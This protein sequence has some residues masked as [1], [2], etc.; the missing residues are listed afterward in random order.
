MYQLCG[1]ACIG[2][3]IGDWSRLV[4]T[5]PLK[6][7]LE[8][9]LPRADVSVLLCYFLSEVTR[10]LCYHAAIPAL[11]V[12]LFVHVWLLPMGADGRHLEAR[13][14]DA[15]AFCNTL[16]ELKTLDHVVN[17]TLA[18]VITKLS[19]L[20][21]ALRARARD[22]PCEE[23][24]WWPSTSH[25]LPDTSRITGWMTRVMLKTKRFRIFHYTYA[26]ITVWHGLTRVMLKP[27]HSEYFIISMSI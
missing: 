17:H 18:F 8:N 25:E 23:R 1:V 4:D 24:V 11:N 10:F 27:K 3:V 13:I 22:F 20:M 21:H 5:F 14:S 16:E 15:S 19:L 6:V 9:A 7:Q 12:V 26:L 2:L